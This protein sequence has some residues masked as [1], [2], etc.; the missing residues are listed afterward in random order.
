LPAQKIFARASGTFAVNEMERHLVE[1]PVV[2]WSTELGEHIL[3]ARVRAFS[4]FG[5][6]VPSGERGWWYVF[7]EPKRIREIVAGEVAFGLRLRP[8]VRVLRETDKGLAEVYV[9]CDS[10]QELSVLLKE[11]RS[12]AAASV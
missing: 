4:L 12:R 5:V 2:F 7:L 6:G 9:S 8:A 11:M 10:T 1:V 3:A